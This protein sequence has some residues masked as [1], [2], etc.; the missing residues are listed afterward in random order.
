MLYS[1]TI[2]EFGKPD[3]NGV[4]VPLSAKEEIL[5]EFRKS[6]GQ[7]IR[8]DTGHG[9]VAEIVDVYIE[10]GKI[11]QDIYEEDEE[12]EGDSTE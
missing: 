1:I 2:L 3:V 8:D 10:D 6:V 11:I 9:I 12:Y 5:K 4:V 7:P